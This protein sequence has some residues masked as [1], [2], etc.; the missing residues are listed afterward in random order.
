MIWYFPVSWEYYRG[1]SRYCTLFLNDHIL[2]HF[3]LSYLIVQT[4]YGSHNIYFFLQPDNPVCNFAVSKNQYEDLP[5]AFLMLFDLKNGTEYQ[6]L[7]VL[8]LSYEILY[9]LH[10][11]FLPYPLLPTRFLSESYHLLYNS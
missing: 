2:F 4:I 7:L 11:W 5:E 6:M 9:P 1:R 10:V 8:H 3:P